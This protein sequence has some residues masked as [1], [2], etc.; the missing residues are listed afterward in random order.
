MVL[1][2]VNRWVAIVQLLS[3]VRFFANPWTAAC[4]TSMS[5]TISQSLLKLM[6]TELIMPSNYLI[7][8]HPLLLLPLIWVVRSSYLTIFLYIWVSLVAQLVKNLPEMQ[9]T[10][11]WFLGQDDAWSRDR[12]P[13][14]VF[15]ASLVAQTARNPPAMWKT[16]VWS[17]GWEDPLEKEMAAPSSILAWRIPWTEEPGGL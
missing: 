9:E 7:L 6:S 2:K 11:V 14:P 3:H 4:Q 5:F 8:C 1:V 12:L 10:L 13:I 17:L 16:W 15:V